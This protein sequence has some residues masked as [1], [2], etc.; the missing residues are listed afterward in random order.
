M[1]KPV[2]EQTEDEKLKGAMQRNEQRKKVEE[3]KLS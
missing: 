2:Q 1:S 3:K